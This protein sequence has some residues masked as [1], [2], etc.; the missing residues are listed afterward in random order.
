MQAQV[1]EGSFLFYL[2]YRHV[3]LSREMLHILQ[4]KSHCN[5]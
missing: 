4:T 3:A 5:T 1:E 2:K